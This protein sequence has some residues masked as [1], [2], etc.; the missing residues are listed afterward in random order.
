MRLGAPLFT[1]VQD[2]QSW[3]AA[4]QAKGYRAAYCPLK[5][6]TDLAAIEVYRRAARA[7]D[8]VIAEVGAW[9][10]PFSPDAA[11]RAAALEKI[12]SSLDLADRI[13]ARCCVNIAGSR[14]ERWAGPSPLDLLDETFDMIVE[15]T[16]AILNEVQP[17]RTYFTLEAMP[18][19]FPDS[20]ESYLRLIHAIDH[21]RFAVHFDPANL[22]NCPQRYY[23]TGALIADFVAKLGPY[24]RSCHIKDV[25]IGNDALVHIDEVRPGLGTLDHATLLR[26]LQPLD[27]E[28][29]IM[30]E[31][32]P[33]EAE[34]DLAAA[35][36]RSVAAQI[37][38]KL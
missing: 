2:P 4:L 22:V 17:T 36:L 12:K 32:L 9:S 37:G 27:P 23:N 10:S 25:L 33:N 15:L 18:A 5:P 13:G 8:I 1:P 30:L 21:P 7:N 38:E 11:V 26:Q 20:A 34:Y 19:M 16:R 28:L 6:G 14:G 24:I 3:I 35:H 29:P 31:H